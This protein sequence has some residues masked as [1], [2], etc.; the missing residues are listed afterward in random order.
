MLEQQHPGIE[1][2]ISSTLLL[3]ETYFSCSSVF[4]L[5][6]SF[7]FFEVPPQPHSAT[8]SPIPVSF[9]FFLSLS[10]I[11]TPLFLIMEARAL[12]DFSATAP[13]ELSFTKSSVLKVRSPHDRQTRVWPSLLFFVLSHRLRKHRDGPLITFSLCVCL[14]ACVFIASEERRESIVRLFSFGSFSLRT[15]RLC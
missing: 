10:L 6:L 8:V 12:H 5:S 15:F 13:D 1:I 9:F 11:L 7:F 3:P 2:E 4:F 14:I